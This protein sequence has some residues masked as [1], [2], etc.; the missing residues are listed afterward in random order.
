M[1]LKKFYRYLCGRRFILV[2]DHKPLLAIFGQ[3]SLL[4]LY[5]AAGLHR[6]SVYMSQFEYDIE[7]RSTLEHGNADTLSRF[8]DS[9]TLEEEEEKE[10]NLIAMENINILPVTHKDIR[11]ATA[12]DQVLS[13]VLSFI[14]NKWPSSMEKEDLELQSYFRKREEPTT[15]EGI[16]LWEIRVVIPHALK[17]KLLKSLHETHAGIVKMK[18]LSRQFIWWPNM[19]KEIEDIATSC[20]NCCA[21]R[22]DPPSAPLH[23]WQFPERPWQRLHIDLAG[24]LQNRMFLIIMDANTK[25]LEIYDMQTNTTNKKVTEKLRDSFVRFGIPEQIVS[26]NGRQFMSSEFQRFCIMEFDTQV[27]HTIHAQ[28]VKLNVSYKHSRRLYIMRRMT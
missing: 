28:M 16:I 21:N 15:H 7:Y 10:V 14:K 12:R 4:Q 11:I 26:D 23:P 25:W 6:W 13:K 17:Q 8:P 22:S 19:D 27:P 2:T 3:K 9:N 18:A 1:R 5:A 20:S 24:P